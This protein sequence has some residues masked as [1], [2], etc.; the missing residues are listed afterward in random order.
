M[1]V[2]DAEESQ[3]KG[4]IDFLAPYTINVVRHRPVD[5]MTREQ[6]GDR[7]IHSADRGRC[8]ALLVSGRIVCSHP[9]RACVQVGDGVPTRSRR[10]RVK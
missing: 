2:D 10:R 9:S 4:P 3:L 7:T 5:A 6:E 8:T 1:M